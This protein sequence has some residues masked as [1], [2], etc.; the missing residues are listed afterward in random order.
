MRENNAIC[1][2]HLLCLFV[3]ANGEIGVLDLDILLASAECVRLHTNF[4][5]SFRGEN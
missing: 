4:N 1:N 2:C 3:I 5:V